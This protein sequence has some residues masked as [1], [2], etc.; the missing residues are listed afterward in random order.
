MEIKFNNNKQN[1]LNE[2]VTIVNKKL[3]ALNLFNSKYKLFL[4]VASTTK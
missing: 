2:V 3:K 1:L 4:F